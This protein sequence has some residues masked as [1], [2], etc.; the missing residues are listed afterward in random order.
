M[1]DELPDPLAAIPLR[2]V[3]AALLAALEFTPFEDVVP[4]LRGL[5]RLGLRLVVVSNWDASLHDVL[6]STGLRAHLDGAITSAELAVA[7]PHP[8]LFH[9]GLGMAGIAPGLAWHVGDSIEEDV[10][11][12]LAAGIEPVLLDRDGTLAA[13][14]PEGVRVIASLAELPALVA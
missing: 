7:K 13:D 14:A 5:R 8:A 2:E 12:A 6:L 1:Q 9:H 3:E 4:A 11:G 10:A